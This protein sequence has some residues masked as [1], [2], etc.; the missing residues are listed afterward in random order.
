MKGSKLSII[1]ILLFQL[2]PRHMFLNFNCKAMPPA[3]KKYS[4]YFISRGVDQHQ[5][6]EDRSKLVLCAD[7][8]RIYSEKVS[9]G[10]KTNIQ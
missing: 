9:G 4:F 8:L 3:R 2:F 6:I 7:I 5:C 1:P 10:N